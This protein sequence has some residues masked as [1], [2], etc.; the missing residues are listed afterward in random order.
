MQLKFD[1][2]LKSF[3]YPIVSDLTNENFKV[4][5]ENG[6]VFV[7]D[8]KDLSLEHVNVSSP[9]KSKDWAI[10]INFIFDQINR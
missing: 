7:I 8:V 9:E 3:K 2:S 6:N 4:F 5:T 1:L 10:F